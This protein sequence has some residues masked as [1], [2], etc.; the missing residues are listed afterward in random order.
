MMAGALILLVGVLACPHDRV[1]GVT[2]WVPNA[3]FIVGYG[4]LACGFFLADASA[5]GCNARPSRRTGR[6]REAEKV[7]SVLA[8]HDPPQDRAHHQQHHG[9]KDEGNPAVLPE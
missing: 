5:Q 7:G 4:L 6:T 3:T 8:A 9:Q 1:D 2:E